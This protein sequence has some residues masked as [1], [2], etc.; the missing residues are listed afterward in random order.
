[1][2][3]TLARRHLDA[4]VIAMIVV[5]TLRG[6]GRQRR[7][8]LIVRPRVTGLVAQV[9]A[10]GTREAHRRVRRAGNAIAEQARQVA[11]PPPDVADAHA[12]SRHHFAVKGR[13]E[14]V[15]G[16][17]D[18][19]GIHLRRRRDGRRVVRVVVRR[20]RRAEPPREQ[21]LVALREQIGVEIGPEVGQRR[22][23]GRAYNTR[24]VDAKAVLK[25]ALA[26][27]VIDEAEAATLT[28]E[29]DQLALL[30][31]CASTEKRRFLTQRR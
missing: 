28:R 7:R 22:L 24:G 13:D 18:Q 19:I 15:R 14:F 17:I 20:R 31:L 16:V 3:E 4:V 6:G 27:D 11:V 10:A 2:A 12:E 9:V 1:M 21:D 8:A 29:E 26:Q 5:V 25:Q 23:A 30:F